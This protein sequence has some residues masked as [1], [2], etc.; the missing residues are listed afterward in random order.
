[1][2]WLTLVSGVVATHSYDVAGG[3]PLENFLDHCLDRKKGYTATKPDFLNDDLLTL[4]KDPS[5]AYPGSPARSN[6]S[7]SSIP[8]VF[9]ITML[10]QCLRQSS[11][12]RNHYII[13]YTFKLLTYL[14]PPHIA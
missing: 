5:D 11:A 7:E 8:S 14:H 4:L 2:A 9:S 10:K 3:A 13:A 1:M 12:H 6:Q